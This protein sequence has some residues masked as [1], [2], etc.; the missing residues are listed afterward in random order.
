MATDPSSGSRGSAASAHASLP[1]PVGELRF[2]VVLDDAVIGAFAECSGL[3]RRVRRLRVRRGRRAAVRA[4]A[5]R[6]AQV[7]EPRAQ[8]GRHLRG[9]AARLVLRP[10]RP[11]RS[12]GA[13][14]STSSATTASRCAAGRS[15]R[16]SPSSGPGRPSAPS[17]RTSRPRPSRSPTRASSPPTRARTDPASSAEPPHRI[18]ARQPRPSRVRSDPINCWFNPKEYTIAKANQWKVDPV[19]GTALP[20]AQFSGGQPRKLTLQLL[21]DGTDSEALDVGDVTARLFKAMEVS[22]ALGSGHGRN[23]GRPPMITFNWG[24]TV[25]FKAVADNLSVQYTLF[26]S[27]GTP[28]R[29]PGAGLAHPGRACDGQV[30]PARCRPCA[31]PDDAR[32]H[33]ASARTRCATAT[34]SRRSPGSTTATR[35]AGARSPRPTA[36]TTRSA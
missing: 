6:R 1:D 31:E 12:A 20:T 8:A 21:F 16:R 34:A 5:P 10:L 22:A 19:T 35:R 30:E 14:R 23:S 28:L 11:R 36:S 7:P 17:R 33:R 26:D 27:D 29:A 18:R 9:R 3:E 13:S 2:Q 24:S 4:Q 25:T 15:T 32:R